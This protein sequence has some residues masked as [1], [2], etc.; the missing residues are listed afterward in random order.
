MVWRRLVMAGGIALM[1]Q[2][3][4][5]EGRPPSDKCPGPPV[6]FQWGGE[7]IEAR[8]AMNAEGIREKY[9]P[10]MAA[11]PNPT[12]CARA[13]GAGESPPAF[14]RSDLIALP[15]LAAKGVCPFY[16]VQ[17]IDGTEAMVAALEKLGVRETFRNVREDGLRCLSK[18]LP[19]G[20]SG[21]DPNT[22]GFGEAGYHAATPIDIGDRSDSEIW[23]LLKDSRRT[24]TWRS[25]VER[26]A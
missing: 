5:A 18:E 19:A 22:P 8:T 9:L 12:T 7:R 16:H 2:G 3:A 20:F 24:M 26:R 10:A 23:S 17:P 6:P 4:L 13:D 21:E 15:S 1:A 14:T 25:T 11:Y